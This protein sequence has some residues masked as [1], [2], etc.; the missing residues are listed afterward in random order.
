MKEN[1]L[2]IAPL[3][4]DEQDKL[5][6]GYINLESNNADTDALFNGNCATNSKGIR[7]GNCGCKQCSADNGDVGT[8]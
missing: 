5:K 7:N 6:G 4:K 2:N 1:E 8:C 3:T